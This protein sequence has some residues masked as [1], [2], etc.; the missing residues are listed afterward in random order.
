VDNDSS[1]VPFRWRERL[2][3]TADDKIKKTLGNLLRCLRMMPQFGKKL[4]YNELSGNVEWNGK[5]VSDVTYGQIRVLIEDE[6]IPF[7]EHDVPIATRLIAEESKYHPIK[8]YLDGLEWDQFPRLHIWTS[9]L[10]GTPNTDYEKAIGTKFLIAAVARVYEPGCKMDNMLVLEGPQN[11]GKSSGLS[12]LFGKEYF[13]EFA[14][15]LRDNPRFVAQMQG[16]WVLE[17]AELAAIRRSEVELVKAAITTSVDKVRLPYG[18]VAEEY[19]RRS[20][21]AATVNP[22]QESGYLTDPT[23]NR[24]FWPLSCSRIDVPLIK[25]KR[26]QLF[27]EAVYRYRLGE[28]W[29][30][31]EDEY[32]TASAEQ[33]QRVSVHPWQEHLQKAISPECRYTTVELLD[34][35]NIPVER[36]THSSKIIVAKCMINLGWVQRR[37]SERY[38]QIPV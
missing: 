10:L 8:D 7:K 12:A 27:A 20:V 21:L 19:P 33:E 15:D 4:R 14:G 28:K 1:V 34:M 16:K 3:C 5:P 38:W 6:N 17:F 23:G 22:A 26:D 18:R 9:I 24:R 32:V 25:D 36:Q 37:G 30:L 2:D 29:W 35:L 31:E 11:I 13:T